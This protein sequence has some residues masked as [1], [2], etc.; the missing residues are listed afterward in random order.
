MYYNG[1]GVEKDLDKAKEL[2]KLAAKT[3][4]NAEILL[5]E[6]ENAN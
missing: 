5:K 1:L 6:L 4:K 3:D 2:Y